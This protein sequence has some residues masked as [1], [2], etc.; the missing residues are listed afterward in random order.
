MKRKYISVLEKKAIHL[1]GYSTVTAYV[2]LIR[3]IID[4]K[5]RYGEFAV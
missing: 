3:L 4:I 5:F 2:I 1:F